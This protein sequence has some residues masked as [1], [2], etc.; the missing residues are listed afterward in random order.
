MTVAPRPEPGDEPSRLRVGDAERDAVVARLQD[1]HVE[2]RLDAVELEERLGT[3]L[4]ARTQAD[5]D[6][7]LA[8]LPSAG[9][10]PARAPSSSVTA[11]VTGEPGLQVSR[12]VL[13]DLVRTGAWRLGAQHSAVA[14]LGDV[15]LDLRS[16]V[17]ESATPV[18]NATAVLGD[19]TVVVP[20]DWE[21]LLEPSSVLGDVEERPAQDPLPRDTSAPVLRVRATAVLGD[22]RVVRAEPD[23]E[24]LGRAA[25]WLERRERRRARR[26]RGRELPPAGR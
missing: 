1:A 22:V 21:V 18:L 4:A 9:R 23:G 6:P 15:R 13:G 26:G 14:V 8:D 5:L 12:T 7:L 19:V 17:L 10:S 2:G 16:V 20:G 3:A 24:V 25:R 11:R